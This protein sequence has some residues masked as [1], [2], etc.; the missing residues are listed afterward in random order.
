MYVCVRACTRVCVCLYLC[1]KPQDEVDSEDKH[2]Y[3][4]SRTDN[5]IKNHWNSTMR[6]KYESEE[7]TGVAS[8]GKRGKG[9][10]KAQSCTPDVYSGVESVSSVHYQTTAPS[11][12]EGAQQPSV[13]PVLV[14][15]YP[16]HATVSLDVYEVR[17]SQSI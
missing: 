2:C 17:L 8:E 16:A 7:K 15:D 4:D 13:Q 14:G 11:F 5:A 9:K 3:F 10:A 12:S 1:L 6:R